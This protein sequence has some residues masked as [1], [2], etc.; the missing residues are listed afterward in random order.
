MTS[1]AA[2]YD[3][4]YHPL[5]TNSQYLKTWGVDSPDLMPYEFTHSLRLPSSHEKL[6]Y[7]VTALSDTFSRHLIYK[8]RYRT[9]TRI[10][11]RKEKDT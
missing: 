5:P 4:I 8:D 7:S 9:Y 2:H 6:S 3:V 10:N 1:Y 11:L